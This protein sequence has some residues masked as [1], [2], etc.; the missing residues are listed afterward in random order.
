LAV[1][2]GVWYTSAV[3]LY[4]QNTP[5]EAAGK[6]SPIP[7]TANPAA[8]ATV[9]KQAGC[10]TCHTLAAASASGQIGP[11]LDTL[12]PSFDVVRAKVESGGGGMPSFSGRL[13]KDQIRDVAAFVAKNAGH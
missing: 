2:I 5:A 9:F 11:N 4:S 12:R 7:A 6:P 3:W 1:L 10:G 8:G 13:N